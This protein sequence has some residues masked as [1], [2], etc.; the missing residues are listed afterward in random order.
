MFIVYRH[1][2]PNGKAYIG[3]TCRPLHHRT[4]RDFA[5]YKECVAFYSATQKYGAAN[6]KTEIL[7]TCEDVHEANRLETLCIARH[8]S[9]APHGY[10]LTTGGSSGL[11]SDET[12]AKLSAAQTGKTHT[13]EVRAKISEAVSGKKHPNWGKTLSTETRAKVSAN[14]ARYWKGKKFS[15][16]TRAKLSAARRGKT[17][18]AE[19]R[20]KNSQTN[21]ENACR[22]R[23]QLL[24]F[25]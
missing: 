4:G 24:L 23:G 12:K 25:N 15:D 19:S 3:Q 6:V 21:R 22:K 1:T 8:N 14:N 17:H 11:L 7:Y 5:G 10:N 9:L 18:S 2:L 20:A 13:D 16:K